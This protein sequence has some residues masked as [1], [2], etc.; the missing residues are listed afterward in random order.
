VEE[1]LRGFAGVADVRSSACRARAA[2]RRSS[3]RSCEAPDT[4][5]DVEAFRAYGR[6]ILT[7]YKVPRQ[8]FF[9]DDLPKS[10]IGKVLRKKVKDSLV[11]GGAT[12]KE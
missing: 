9:V 10:L 2:A 1:V 5:V 8:V 7:P 12:A 11:E 3:R 6:E 4:T